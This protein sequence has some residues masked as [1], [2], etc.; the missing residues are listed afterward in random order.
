MLLTK[1]YATPASLSED[2]RH[3]WRV[4]VQLGM[5]GSVPSTLT[6]SM[7]PEAR[8]R[9]RFADPLSWSGYGM[10]ISQFLPSTKSARKRKYVAFAKPGARRIRHGTSL[11]AVEATFS[12]LS[13]FKQ[14]AF[15]GLSSSWKVGSSGAFSSGASTETAEQKLSIASQ[16]AHQ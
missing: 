8:V 2:A 10:I 7:S 3:L 5:A 12:S 1:K 9:F 4:G 15:I 13:T 11:F 6:E 14:N 16:L